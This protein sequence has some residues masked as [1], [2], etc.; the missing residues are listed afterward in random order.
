MTE[1]EPSAK[2]MHATFAVV[3][4]C[5]IILFYFMSTQ[6][7]CS[8]VHLRDSYYNLFSIGFVLFGVVPPVIYVISNVIIF[9]KKGVKLT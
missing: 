2:M 3:W 7:D 1:K 4:T 5:A 8:K 6:I 9:R